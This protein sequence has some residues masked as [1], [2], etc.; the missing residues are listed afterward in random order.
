MSFTDVVRALTVYP[1]IPNLIGLALVAMYFNKKRSFDFFNWVWI[2]PLVALAIEIIRS[3]V[4]TNS[5]SLFALSPWS[6]TLWFLA[7]GFGSV[8]G[9]A[10]SI[11][12][13][14]VS[15]A[16]RYKLTLTDEAS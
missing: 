4:L 16:W 8:T 14:L 6:P 5:G 1:L 11:G 3:L 2:S 10:Y 12:A 15:L 9:V 7:Y 13:A